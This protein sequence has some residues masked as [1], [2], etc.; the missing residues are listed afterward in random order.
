MQDL[1]ND[2]PQTL[3]TTSPQRTFRTTLQTLHYDW[4]N[5]FD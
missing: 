5:S 3:Q 4:L 2:G 1:E